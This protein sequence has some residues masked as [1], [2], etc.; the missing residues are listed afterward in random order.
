MNTW[1]LDVCERSYK[2]MNGSMSV[3]SA[4]HT[5]DEQLQGPLGGGTTQLAHASERY[6][7]HG[8]LDIDDESYAIA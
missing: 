3:G 4:L 2:R 5:S 8:T 7:R 1:Q 6:A